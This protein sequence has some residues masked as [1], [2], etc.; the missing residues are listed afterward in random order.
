MSGKNVAS[1]SEVS[2]PLSMLFRFSSR[3]NR[4]HTIH[5]RIWGEDAFQEAVQQD[6]PIFLLI[7]SSWCQW[8]HIMDETTLS[9]MSIIT[10]VNNDYIPIRVDSDMRPD[11]NARYNQN[12]WPSVVLLSSEGEILWGGVYVPPKQML[13]YLGHV[14]RYYSEHRQEI[15]EQVQGLHD[16]RFT[17]SLTQAL[18]AIGQRTL[19]DE[20]RTA[21]TDVPRQAGLVLRDLYDAEYGGFTIHQHL[22]FP[23]P[24]ALE[25]LLQLAKHEPSDTTTLTG[26]VSYTLGQMRDGGL[27][28]KE[29]G[30]FFRYS[31][32]SD[33]ST[34]HTEKMLEE[35]AALLHL[36]VYTAQVTQD[37]QWCELARRLILYC[38]STLWLPD[39][40]VFGGSQRA[41][42]EYY[43]PALYSRATRTRPSVDTTV[44]T[45]WNAHMVSAYGLAAK[46]LHLPA[47]DK[48]A[49]NVLDW[50]CE[51]M[52]DNEGCVYHYAA[53]GSIAL[54]GQLTD[55]VWMTR[56]LLDAYE[57]Y[58]IKKYL[59]MAHLLMHFVCQELF[60]QE[61]GLFYDG[62]YDEHGVG[63]ASMRM[64][65]LTE[66]ALAAE[67]LLRM[68]AFA[69][70]QHLRDRGLSVLSH[71]LDKYRRT[72]IQGAVYASVVLRVLEKRW[73]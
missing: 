52:M 62:L 61:N 46:V 27:W 41:D 24:E 22:K 3:P 8:C 44:Y 47:L 55:S 53:H 18:P 57:R 9:E 10:I 13:Y 69:E 63:R 34:P 23:H 50:L 49:L 33:W 43:E 58:G 7:T 31:A 15:T 36:I 6:K 45:S 19:L 60:D 25:L 68:A 42:E 40:G 70:Q 12:G 72:G 26:M 30:G 4:A 29:D 65:P 32:A 48:M 64:H 67:C 71:C 39:V 59:E 35:N 56:A 20:Q 21:V 37:G 54:P 66:N 2:L 51:H 5:W 16:A 11:I 38:N 28:D 14:R 17:R 1:H 73:L